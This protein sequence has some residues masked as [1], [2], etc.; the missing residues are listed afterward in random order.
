MSVIP[1]SR[2]CQLQLLNGLTLESSR[3][4]RDIVVVPLLEM[5]NVYAMMSPKLASS[6][7]PLYDPVVS[8][9]WVC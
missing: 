8:V 2:D 9:H 5:L 3:V 7:L 6:M 4:G 1:K